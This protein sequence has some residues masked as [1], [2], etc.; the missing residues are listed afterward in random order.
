MGEN[1]AKATSSRIYAEILFFHVRINLRSPEVN[2]VSSSST[3]ACTNYMNF[4]Q[5]KTTVILKHSSVI[6][7]VFFFKKKGRGEHVSS[8]LG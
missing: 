5:G 6:F 7:I 4:F 3:S 1:E 2:K 8:L